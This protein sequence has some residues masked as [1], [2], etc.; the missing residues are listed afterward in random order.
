ME[1]LSDQEGLKLNAAPMDAEQGVDLVR[2]RVWHNPSPDLRSSWLEVLT[3]TKRW[4]RW[5]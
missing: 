3:E 2:L 1:A 4:I 5:R